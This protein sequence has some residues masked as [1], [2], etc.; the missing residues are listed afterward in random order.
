M[1]V[2]YDDDTAV[3]VDWKSGRHLDGYDGQMELFAVAAMIRLPNIQEV[4]TALVSTVT[5]EK[6]VKMFP[7]ASLKPLIGKWTDIANAMLADVDLEPTPGAYCRWCDFS[8][9]NGGPCRYG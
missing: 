6:V 7:R 5:G 2:V 1:G 8:H 3:I 9:S 4:Q